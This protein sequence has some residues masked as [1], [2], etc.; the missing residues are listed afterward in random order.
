MSNNS[1][2][3]WSLSRFLQTY[4]MVE[5]LHDMLQPVVEAVARCGEPLRQIKSAVKQNS[6]RFDDVVGKI[7]DAGRGLWVI[8]ELGEAQFVWWDYMTEEFIDGIEFSENIN[9]FLRQYILQDKARKVDNTI[10]MI[11]ANPI[12][13]KHLRIFDQS[14]EAYKRGSSD[15]AVTGFTSV[16]DGLLSVVSNNS[17]SGMKFRAGII[18]DKLENDEVLNNDEY[19]MLTFALTFEK[20]LDSF[21]APSDF[22]EKEPKGLNRHWIAHGRST[23]KKTKLD[24]VKMINLIYG[25]LMIED[26]ES[27]AS[28]NSSFGNGG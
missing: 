11:R 18:K 17:G 24:C 13:N 12:M 7:V 23:R 8:R 5:S 22:K 21:S 16:F 28:S 20:T 6:L 1:S 2:E 15:L 26:L 27:T 19:A 10:E 9:K 4:K 3:D 14:V 25:L